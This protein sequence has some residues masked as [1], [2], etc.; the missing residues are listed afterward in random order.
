MPITIPK[1]QKKEEK[2]PSRSGKKI[3]FQSPKGMHDILPV[4]FAYREK[5]EKVLK[6]AAAFFDFERIETPIL[7]DVRLFERG[8][9]L[10]SEVVQKQMFLVKAKGDITLVMR[11]EMTPSIVRAYVQ[12][13]LVHTVSP[14]KFFYCSPIFRHE[15]PQHGRFREFYQLGFEIL[16]TDDSVYDVQIISAAYKIL[17]ELKIKNS[18]IKLNTIGCKVCRGTYVKKLKEYYK[19]KSSQL[20]KDCVVRLGE[21]PLRLLD[22]KNEKCQP[23]KEN[24]PQTLDSLCTSC[25]TH[26]TSVLEMLDGIGIPYLIDQTLVR[27]LDYYTRT[28]FEIFTEG[29]DAALGGGGRYDYLS[30]TLGGPKM[31]GVGCALGMERIVEVMKMQRI[32]PPAKQ[33]FKVFLMYMGDQAK[34]RAVA[35]M[36]EFYQAGV[37]IKESFTKE[38]LKA[39]LRNA[40]KEQVD[41]A[42]I[43]GQREVFEDVIILR[44]MKHGSQETIPLKKIIAEV[45]KR[46]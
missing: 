2:K 46:I 33:S 14:G 39:Q 21:N 16:N 27:G 1:A 41:Y 32:E 34:K 22:C 10:T 38:S 43:L 5:I 13:G 20:C 30:E 6:K 31:P 7:E 9:G 45:K 18:T 28:V 15:Q 24:A 37:P 3:P 29:F 25:K 11:P 40:D 4:D 23:L 19:G 44:D 36:E 35:L 12:N 26:F 42:L 17:T 8:T